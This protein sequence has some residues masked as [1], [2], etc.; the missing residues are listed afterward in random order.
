[1]QLSLQQGATFF[2]HSVGQMRRRQ[3]C[4]AEMRNCRPFIFIV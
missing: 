1:M 4:K 2:R 3:R